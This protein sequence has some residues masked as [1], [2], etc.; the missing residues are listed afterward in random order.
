MNAS[1]FADKLRCAHCG[2]TNA[3]KEWPA[4]GDRVP[5]Y[6]QREPGQFCLKL[7]CPHCKKDWYVAWDI[8]PGPAAPLAEAVAPE[9][10]EGSQRGR[11]SRWLYVLYTCEVCRRIQ[12][13]RRL[14]PMPLRASTRDRADE[15]AVRLATE[16]QTFEWSP[17]TGPDQ[18]CGHCQSWMDRTASVRLLVV[19]LAGF[20]T[21]VLM[22][23]AVGAAAVAAESWS[24]L[25]VVVYAG[26]V[27]IC[28][29]LLIRYARWEKRCAAARGAAMKDAIATGMVLHLGVHYE[30]AG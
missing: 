21:L 1:V 12:F 22:A 16:G 10:A 8:D 24:L 18:S 7:N 11:T 15:L 28:V 6:Y 9:E 5:F 20:G 13:T 19:L 17:S 23:G 14:L 26:F 25:P 29:V 2:E 27:G 30:Q 4:N 3:A